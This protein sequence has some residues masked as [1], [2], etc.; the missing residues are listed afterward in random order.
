MRHA[1]VGLLEKQRDAWLQP[2]EFRRKRDIIASRIQ[3]LALLDDAL[4]DEWNRRAA[5]EFVRVNFDALVEK[6]PQ[7]RRAAGRALPPP[8]GG[9]GRG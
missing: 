5:F 6:L 2:A 3:P 9:L 7:H 4:K 1:A 8:G